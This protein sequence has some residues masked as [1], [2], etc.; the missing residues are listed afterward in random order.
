MVYDR[1]GGKDLSCQAT[2]KHTLL[3]LYVFYETFLL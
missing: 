3:F 2:K 1:G